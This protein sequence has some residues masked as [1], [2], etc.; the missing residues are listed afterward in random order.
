MVSYGNREYED[1]L[2][3][4]TDILTKQGFNIVGAGAFITKHS[5]FQEVANKRP[6]Y[7]DEEII[8][9]FSK[10][11]IETITTNRF[12]KL[13]INGNR[14]YIEKRHLELFPIGDSNCI[15]C[16]DCKRICP[17]EAIK[18]GNF[19]ETNKEKCISCTAC[20]YTCPVGSRGYH[21]ENFAKAYE[22]FK[23]VN[24]KRKEPELF[25]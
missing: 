19:I 16:G 13:K 2:L 1:S 11:C 15:E 25:I 17:V 8:K 10:K 20:I 18:E 14:P 21:Y 24:S 9:S 23:E 7:D 22:K 3:E 6:D 12:K 5:I 4:L